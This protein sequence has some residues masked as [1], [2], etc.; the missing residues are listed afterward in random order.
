MIRTLKGIAKGSL[1]LVQWLAPVILTP[2]EA[3]K[4]SRFKAGDEG[5]GTVKCNS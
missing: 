2:W 5:V 4:R 3:E 1:S